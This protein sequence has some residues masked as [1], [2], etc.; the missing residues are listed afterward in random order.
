MTLLK[1]RNCTVNVDT[2]S[3][4]EL[5][6]DRK[7]Y[8]ALGQI[9]SNEGQ[10]AETDVVLE[11]NAP[12]Q[13]II[14]CN[15]AQ[16]IPFPPTLGP[17]KAILLPA[18][19]F[20]LRVWEKLGLELGEAAIYTTGNSLSRLVGQV[21]LWRGASPV[22]QLGKEEENNSKSH[23]VEFL[24]I[25]DAEDSIRL[26]SNRIKNKPG[27]AIVELSGNP[28]IIDIIL[29]IIPKWGRIICAAHSG[30]PLTIDFY[31]NIHRKGV[32]VQSYMYGQNSLLINN[33]NELE[34]LIQQA[35]Q[36]LSNEEMS[37]ICKE[38]IYER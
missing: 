34:D 26:L 28:E 7:R 25:D 12:D 17:E 31:N 13:N 37:A 4:L 29:E 5:T 2:N 10:S 3:V 14:E 15:C 35:C 20:A 38:L 32:I 19:I 6:L 30:S 24:A 18:L 8:F 22:I 1:L 27:I 23:L 21:A 16:C 33:S 11:I 9:D 36:I